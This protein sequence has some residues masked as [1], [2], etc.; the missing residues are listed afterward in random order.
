MQERV[1]NL[2][3]ETERK[4]EREYVTNLKLLLHQR[5]NI[6]CKTISNKTPLLRVSAAG[7]IKPVESS[8]SISLASTDLFLMD[9]TRSIS[10]IT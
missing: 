7:N 3:A 8:C 4:R 10:A 6:E 1:L 9:S 2:V 5:A